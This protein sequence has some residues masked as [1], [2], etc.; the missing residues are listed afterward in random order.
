[1]IRS[2]SLIPTHGVQPDV[3]KTW[4]LDFLVSLIAISCPQLEDL[5]L[6]NCTQVSDKSMLLVGR[7]CK[8]LKRLNLNR[9]DRVSSLSIDA[10]AQTCHK[11]VMLNLSRPLLHPA[12][13]LKDESI[14]RLV[15][16]NSGLK[17]LRLRNCELVTDKTVIELS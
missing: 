17:E 3:F 7:H 2:V 4:N 5:I 15:K 11:L 14:L 8:N 10:L 1:M 9:C 16:A 12:S 6:S 13:Q